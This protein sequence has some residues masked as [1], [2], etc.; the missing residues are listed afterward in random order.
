MPKTTKQQ[1]IDSLDK[2]IDVISNVQKVITSMQ[3]NMEVLNGNM[4]GAIDQIEEIQVIVD[5][6]KYR[7]G[8]E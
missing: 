4:Q 7:M 1:E 2:T 5:K 3:S 8:L 6:M